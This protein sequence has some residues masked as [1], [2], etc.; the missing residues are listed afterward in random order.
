LSA[1]SGLNVVSL[2]VKSWFCRFVCCCCFIIGD[3]S[4][5]GSPIIVTIWKVVFANNSRT[6][7]QIWMKLSRWGWGLKRLS[8]A[9]FQRNHAIRFGEST[10]NWSQRRWFICLVSDAPLLPLSLDRFPPNFPR[11]RVQVVARKHGFIFQ[12][13]FH[14]G[15]KFP[16]KTSF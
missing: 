16:E 9:R 12:K 4:L 13:S 7:G 2:T 8:L 5:I 10:K 1:D 6:L 11:T 15:I 14:Y 3:P